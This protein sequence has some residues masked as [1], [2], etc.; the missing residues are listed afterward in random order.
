MMS[1]AQ[2][3]EVP[4]S[5]FESMLKFSNLVTKIALFP[6]ACTIIATNICD[7]LVISMHQLCTTMYLMYCPNS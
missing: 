5:T 4:I 1:K 6:I 2:S 3:S 7:V